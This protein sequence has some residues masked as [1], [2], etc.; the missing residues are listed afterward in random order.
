MSDSD[1]SCTA[2]T[3]ATVEVGNNTQHAVTLCNVPWAPGK[4]CVTLKGL[5]DLKPSTACQAFN[6][7]AHAINPTRNPAG[8]CTAQDGAAEQDV[9]SEPDKYK[10]HFCEAPR[11]QCLAPET[12][13]PPGVTDA[14]CTSQMQGLEH[15]DLQVARYLCTAPCVLQDNPPCLDGIIS[16]FQAR[17]A[18][19]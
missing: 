16:M 7:K 12:G 4:T 19:D 13:A 10:L 14:W 6:D 17:S 11:V 1:C 5:K 9:G 8:T 18:S 3:T 15:A 2:A